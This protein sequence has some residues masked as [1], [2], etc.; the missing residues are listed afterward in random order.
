MLALEPPAFYQAYRGTAIHFCYSEGQVSQDFDKAFDAVVG[1]EG[2]YVN[3]P[4]DPGGETKF[5]ITKRTYPDLDIKSLTIGQAKD[6]YAKDFW[7]PVHGDDLP[8]PLNLFLFDSA[9]N[10]NVAPAVAMLQ[11]ALGQKQD[12]IMGP[13]TVA[14]AKAAEPKEL[15]AM[16]MAHR[17]LRYTGTRHFDI[18]G[19]GWLKRLFRVVIDA[20]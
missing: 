12:G 7:A 3:D 4:N 8:W 11:R 13:K 18:Y 2:A 14:A 16:F 19:R 1:I 20:T 10:Q 17:A 6:I 5:G 9:V 15:C